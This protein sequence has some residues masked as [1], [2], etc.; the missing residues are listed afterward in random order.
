MT[1]IDVDAIVVWDDELNV[2]AVFSRP[3]RRRRTTCPVSRVENKDWIT[4]F[5][6]IGVL[7]PNVTNFAD[8]VIAGSLGVT[9]VSDLGAWDI[10]LLGE[11][12]R[13]RICVRTSTEKV[14]YFR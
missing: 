13:D 8:N 5:N 1:S 11:V 2:A 7:F 12:F 4:V 14:F 10:Q 3:S 9:Q 6:M